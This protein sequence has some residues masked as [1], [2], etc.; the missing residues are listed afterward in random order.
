MSAERAWPASLAASEGARTARTGRWTSVLII[1]AVALLTAAPAV[2]DT[3]GVTSLIEHEAAWVAA[4]GRVLIATGPSADGASTPL[5]ARTCE[6]LSGLDGVTGSFALKD[7]A[8]V[9]TL[10]H[11]PG[12][13]VSMYDVSSGAFDLLGIDAAADGVVIVSGG[14]SERTG[15]VDGDTVSVAVVEGSGTMGQTSAPL[16]VRVADTSRL[17]DQ[18]DGALFTPALLTGDADTCYVETDAAHYA[19]VKDSLSS[20]L[21]SEAGPAVVAT[22]LLQSEFTVDYTTAFQDRP[23][24]WL[25]AAAAL[26]LSLLWAM[27]QWFRRSQIAIYATFSMKAFPRMLMQATEWAVLATAG[28][29]LGWCG[30]IGL[31]TLLTGDAHTAVALGSAHAALTLIS[32]TVVV[33]GLG[34]RPAG[35]LLAALKDR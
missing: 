22:R 20:L 12:G 23:L 35:S 30:G 5:D 33:I 4:G 27:V 11:L 19:T 14:L 21:A 34:L 28:G 7:T 16:R 24:R 10:A 8:Q 32:T 26:V 31:A 1:V 3:L 25:W 6:G 2:A 13:R 15:V 17:G 18:F 29:L 9:A